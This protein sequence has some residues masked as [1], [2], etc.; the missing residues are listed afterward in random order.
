[1]DNNK[2]KDLK[3]IESYENLFHDFVTPV[4]V[5]YNAIQLLEFEKQSFSEQ[6]KNNV[7]IIKSNC[8]NLLKLIENFRSLKK[9][10]YN[11][12]PYFK[13]YDIVNI[14]KDIIDSVLLKAEERKQK[15][16]FNSSKK[17]YH[18]IFDESIYFKIL[19]NLISNSLKFN[20]ENGTI[21]INLD[22]T[23][24]LCLLTVKDTGIGID[25]KAIN[26]IFERNFKDNSNLN[27]T[28]T[29][30]GLNIVHELINIHKGTITAR[31]NK[32]SKGAEFIVKLPLN[33]EETED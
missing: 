3:I 8:N 25:E 17:E 11:I 6:T 18:M 15:I 22:F 33:I 28:G 31:S 4:S 27:K 21:N 10:D 12:K 14:T 16:I 2:D 26:Q 30:L 13:K 20:S 32:D 19:V 5:I 24:K 1:M 9:Q 23:E 7:K 29:G